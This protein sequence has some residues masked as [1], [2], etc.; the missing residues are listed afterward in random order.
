MVRYPY[1]PKRPMHTLP[2][3]SAALLCLALL[4]SSPVQAAPKPVPGTLDAQCQ[5][6]HSKTRFGF[7]LGLHYSNI[8]HLPDDPGFAQTD[9]GLGFRMG[10]LADVPIN[11]WMAFVPKAELALSSGSVLLTGVDGNVNPYDIR[12]LAAELAPHMVFRP[13][14]KRT[15][16]YFLLGP[17]VRLPFHGENSTTSFRTGWDVALDL[18]IGLE[19]VFRRLALAPEL[20]YSVGLMDI[21]QQP[22][23]QSVQLHNVSLVLHFKG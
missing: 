15:M 7:S 9:N 1:K 12:A 3:I 5:T 22:Q 16:P 8:L 20:R 18:S 13:E 10:V 4:E 14:G 6:G 19:Q 2:M 17:N 21:N 23:L 11:A